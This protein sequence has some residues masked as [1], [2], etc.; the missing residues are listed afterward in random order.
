MTAGQLAALIAA[1][2][3]AIGVCAGVWVL[4][5]LAGLIR[6][7]TAAVTG[8]QQGADELLRRAHAAVDQAEAQ[9]SRTGQLADSVEQVSASMSDLSEQVSAVAGTAR[10]IAAGLGAP[11]LRLAAAG[12]GVRRAL[13]IRRAGHD[14]G[15]PHGGGPARKALR[16]GSRPAGN[17]RAAR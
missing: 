4:W 5:R 2:F 15:L 8:Y 3:F 1:G 9:L 17:E 14:R 12:H 6:A 13:A 10:L 7:A 11:V 16:A